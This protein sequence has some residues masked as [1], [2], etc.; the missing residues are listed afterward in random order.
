MLRYRFESSGQAQFQ[1]GQMEMGQGNAQIHLFDEFLAFGEPGL[2][3]GVKVVG[4]SVFAH[5]PGL[6]VFGGGRQTHHLQR[7]GIGTGQLLGQRSVKIR[8]IEQLLPLFSGGGF[9]RGAH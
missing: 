7:L 6:G 8:L 3:V 2:I 9:H 1:S 5:T 4:V